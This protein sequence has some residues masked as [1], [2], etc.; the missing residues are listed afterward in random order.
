[1]RPGD[2]KLVVVPQIDKTWFFNLAEDPAALNNLADQEAAIVADI[3][4][5][6]ARH[7]AEMVLPLWDWVSALP[8]NVDKHSSGGR[9]RR[10]QLHLLE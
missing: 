5:L 1:M 10:E 8:N 7:N 6:L 2:W 4:A 9:S 3:E